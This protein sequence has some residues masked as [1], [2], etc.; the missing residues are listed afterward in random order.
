MVP[1][2]R[3]PLLKGDVEA[4]AYQ[5]EAAKDAL[6]GSTL[7]VM[8]TGLGKTAVQWMAMAELLSENGKIVLVAPTIGL[9]AQ[10]FKM[11]KQFLNIQSESIIMLTGQTSPNRREQLWKQARIVIAT[12]H[13]IRND[14]TTGR[15]SLSDVNLL[16]VDEAHHA[17]GSNSVAQLADLYLQASS[18]A[19]ILAATAS[20]GVKSVKIMEIINRLGIERLHVT[21]KT[22]DLV[23]PYSTS[24]D[25]LKHQINLPEELLEMIQPIKIL[26]AE[27]AGYLSRV[28]FLPKSDR[29]TTAIIEEAKRRASAAIGRGNP[30]GYDA[31]KRIAD[32]RRIHRLVDLLETQGVKCALKYLH[33]S[34]F[35]NNRKTKRFL[36]MQA[37]ADFRSEVDSSTEHHPKL[38]KVR[39]IVSSG[40][41]NNGKVIVFTE[42]RDTVDILIEKLSENSLVK[43]GKFVGQTSKGDQIGMRQKEQIQQLERFKS[44]QINVLIATS[45]GEEGLD[46]PAADSVVLYEPVPSAIR[47]IQRRGRTARQKD[48]D[49]HIL[50]A[51][52]TRDQYV[53]YASVKKEEAM[54]KSLNSLQKQSRLPRRA[55]PKDDVLS[56]FSVGNISVEEFIESEKIRL[57]R[58][59]EEKISPP[60][61]DINPKKISLSNKPKSQKSLVDFAMPN[62]TQ[63]RRDTSQRYASLS[64]ERE[65][66]IKTSD[67]AKSTIDSIHNKTKVQ[68]CIVVDHRE[69]SS[70]LPE[71]LKMHGHDVSLEHLNVGDVKISD[72]ILI[73]RKSA[74][75]LIDSII[76]GRLISQAR[77]LQSSASRPLIVIESIESDR[78]HPNAVY[79]AMAWITLDL[80]LPVVV[81][82][83]VEETARFISVAAKRES[84]ITDLIVANV[85][86]KTRDFEK[87]AIKAAS[88]E[89]MAI[90]NGER[91]SGFLSKK[92]EKEVIQQRVKIL[93]ELPG[94]GRM[95]AER[96][97]HEAKDIVGLCSMSE[98]Q[99]VEIEGI[100]SQQASNLYQFLHG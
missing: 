14:A 1:I 9:V 39:E 72:R 22:D 42:Y 47:A 8:P 61:E 56:S 25:I 27:E 54:Y 15:I 36:S 10:Q 79:G 16:I 48:G 85:R 3:H 33:R 68:T 96:I 5:L 65:K 91:E 88:A 40:I 41:K 29:V 4:R 55:P 51:K 38:D 92:W 95:S 64:S 59:N 34:K 12:P 21:R 43:P 98:R 32:L 100:S 70:K 46:V 93:S 73:E 58:K 31:A 20:P 87:S 17:T 50:I 77:K 83:T 86:K 57:K 97:M 76:D 80:G 44:G 19:M 45:V 2:L 90:I 18:R 78:L 99:L 63:L 66:E 82:K 13:V 24:M 52:G 62:D 74:R 49:V 67:A 69:A 7:L 60:P 23:V 53:Q 71:L 89:I 11:A 81:T 75:D 6:S 35:D 28:G 26:E 30:R 37:V 84:R 94:I